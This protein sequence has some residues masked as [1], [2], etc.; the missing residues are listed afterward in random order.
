MKQTSL[1]TQ[2][3]YSVLLNE[4]LNA[5]VAFL[6][7]ASAPV[8]III[9]VSLGSGLSES[10]I[11][12]WIFAVFVFNGL[13]SIAMS[14]SYRQPLVFLWTIPG[15]ILVGTALKTLPFEEIIGAYILTGVLLLCLGLTGWVKKV[16]DWLP[17]PVVMG[18]VAGVF[19]SFGVDWIKAF[20]ADFFLVSAMS[21]TFL[22][23]TILYRLPLILPPLIYALIVGIII[24]FERQGLEIGEVAFAASLVTP[25]TYIPEFS[26]SAALELV[27]PLAVTV[28]AAQ[29]AQGIVVLKNVGHNP[30]VNMITSYCGFMSLFTALY[31]GISTCLTGPV[32]AIIVSSNRPDVHWVAAI[33][34]GVFAILF[35]LTA[36]TVTN[37]LI[38]APP[39]FLAT[40]A[41]L[42]L[43]KTLQSA[44]SGAFNSSHP[45]GGLI[46]FLVTLGGIPMLNIGSPFWGLAFGAIISFLL[47]RK[48]SSYKKK[49]Q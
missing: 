18:M 36:P 16:M 7:A 14:V 40:L 21:A 41:G 24:I 23:V 30:P 5:F 4:F 13:L 48:S 2:G 12:S 35:G 47:E 1:G 19:V 45:M 29:N 3:S 42:A 20:E 9:S 6:F 22:T 38:A 32:N 10:D 46:A 39:A 15:A 31:G 44:F 33:F 28:I 26:L 43:L 34:L 25:K 49:S 27:V 11:S 8:A 17:M 37:I